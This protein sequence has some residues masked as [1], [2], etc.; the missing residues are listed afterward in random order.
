[1]TVTPSGMTAPLFILRAGGEQIEN[2]PPAVDLG[3]RAPALSVA[4]LPDR[5]KYD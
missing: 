3:R 4:A 5:G 2:R 1:M